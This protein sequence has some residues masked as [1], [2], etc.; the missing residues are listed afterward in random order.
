MN[1]DEYDVI[2]KAYKR[3]EPYQYFETYLQVA[4]LTRYHL[5]NTEQ[6]DAKMLRIMQNPSEYRSWKS[7]MDIGGIGMKIKEGKII[8]L[9]NNL[10]P[11]LEDTK[12]DY[13]DLKVKFPSMFIN[14]KI[15]I[16][17]CSVSGFLI[18]DV[19]QIKE[20]H[21]ELRFES[22][23][24]PQGNLRILSIVLN[25]KGEYEFFSIQPFTKKITPYTDKK[26]GKDMAKISKKINILACNLINLIANDEKD[27]EYINVKAT[28]NKKRIKRGKPP[29][30]DVMFIRLGGKL[31]RYASYYS[32]FRNPSN[33]RYFVGGFWRHF[34]SDFYKQMKGKK[35][36]VKCFYRNMNA[37]D[38]SI[39]RFIEIKK[40]K[41]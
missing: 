27:I 11:L 41:Q 28:N 22:T 13:V 33:V 24:H 19:D 5:E 12:P 35:I 36:W 1:K 29:Q 38:E 6:P 32:K 15:S 10:I 31:K 20:F 23:N 25:T 17:D 16:G 8:K 2:K 34:K 9:D 18:V 7:F 14:H 37:D 21:P 3:L 4:E 40:V 30:R 39:P 26:D